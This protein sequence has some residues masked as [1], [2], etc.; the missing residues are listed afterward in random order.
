MRV[1]VIGAGAIGGFIAAALARSGADVGIVARG[2]H[3]EAVRKHGI[4]VISSDLGSFTAR[5]RAS[6]MHRGGPA[7][8]VYVMLSSLS[9]SGRKVL[10]E[11]PGWIKKV[12]ADVQRMGA[13]V[14]AQY[15][16]LGPYDFVTIVEAP[17]NAT[18]DITRRTIMTT[19]RAA[20][21]PHA[22][23]GAARASRRR[24]CPDTAPPLPALLP[25]PPA[26]VTQRPRVRSIALRRTIV[27]IACAAA[28]LS[29]AS[30]ALAS[31]AVFL[32]AGDVI[33]YGL[34]IDV[35]VHVAPAPHTVLIVGLGAGLSLGCRVLGGLALIYALVGFVPLWRMEIEQQGWREAG[36]RFIRT[37]YLLLPGLLLGYLIMGLIWPWSIMEPGNPLRAVTY[38]SAF[39]EKP[40]KELFDGTMVSVPDMPWSYLP[41]LFALQL[42][43]VLLALSIAAVIGTFMSLSHRD[44]SA[45]RKTIFLMLTLALA[46]MVYFIAFK[47]R[48]VTRGD[49]GLQGIP[50]PA[51]GPW[52]LQTT[53]PSFALGPSP[54]ATLLWKIFS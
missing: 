23:I 7:V 38:F 26:R 14:V 1:A 27:A 5:V 35:D 49:D 17:D 48:S 36:Y 43:E 16:V 12:N 13:R 21:E 44:V 50:S 41:T 42:P 9:E 8:S 28:A 47:W 3:L 34:T 10:R 46:Q 37:S 45:R 24:S 18:I 40:W 20:R 31:N 2:A 15:A 32:H 52:D 4:E 51:I 54:A 39:F 33:R 22:H 53:L 19:P 25:L 29:V 30:S 11:R 6:S